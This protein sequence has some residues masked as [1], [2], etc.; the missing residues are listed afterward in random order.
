MTSPVSTDKASQG[1][2]RSAAVPACEACRKMKMK[3]TRSVPLGTAPSPTTPCDRCKRTNRTCK[4][5]ESRPL[6]R[7]RGA[8]GRYRGF[9]KAYRKLQSEAKKVN[10]SQ[11]VDEID[12]AV[13]LRRGE[14]LGV[15]SFLLPQ[16]PTPDDA[17]AQSGIVAPSH[18]VNTTRASIQVDCENGKENQ[19]L[20]AP[21]PMSNPL[22]LLAHASDAAQAI[23]ASTVASSTLNSPASRD[24]GSHNA[25]ETEGYRLLHRPG[26]ISLG[27][28]LDRSSLVQGLDTLLANLHTGHQS[29]DYFNRAGARQ[30]DVGPDLDPIELGLVTMDD[31][32][33]LFPIYFARLHP[34]N[35]ILDPMLH[36]PEFVRAR[37]SLLFTWILALTAQFDHA[38]APIA[39]R[40][41][42]HGDKLSKYVHTCGYKSVEI[43]Q[44]YY[45]SLLSATPAKTLAEERSWLYTMYAIGVATD[46]GLD[47]GPRAAIHS[48]PPRSRNERQFSFPNS[49][50]GAG[51]GAHQPPQGPSAEETAY[52][53][54][55]F[56]N[57]ERT[58]LRILLWERANSAAS[59]RI[60]S[61][62]ESN[63]T[64]SIDTW[65]LHPLSDTTD[66]YTA[67]FIILRQLLA[68]L[69]VELRDHTRLPHSDPHWVRHL[70][71]STLQDW[72]NTW[73]A[74]QQNNISMIYLHYVYA[75]GRLWTL[76]LALNSSVASTQ[77]LDAIRQDCFESAINCC[78]TA[79]RDL[80]TIGEPLYCMLAPTWAMISYAAVLTLKLFPALYG[81]RLGSDVELLS[82]LSQVA[83]QLQRAGTTPSH[84]FGIA[85]LLGQHLMMIL[86]AR[87]VGLIESPEIREP[88]PVS[89]WQ[90]AT[91]VARRE[92]LLLTDWDPFLTQA[93]SDRCDAD[94]DGFA[95]LFREIF[96]PGFGDLV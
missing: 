3:C 14:E 90:S 84:R 72:C 85:A 57:R 64:R 58:W 5:P 62:P 46:L 74:V 77:E 44:G 54:R 56:R 37:S 76:S 63:L 86:R 92:N 17:R 31:A 75:H 29:L 21:E 9:E 95:D 73:L 47:Q 36:T 33:R 93:M 13:C 7:K 43:V 1:R 65:W 94:G 42:L 91:P 11:G 16:I 87:A 22:A 10:L 59:G 18:E 15:E 41:R 79:V 24:Q 78:E 2:T 32:K 67:A 66:Q 53:Q 81:S 71:D 19:V 6:G 70:V 25:G 39:E 26:Y 30:S 4:I 69:Q 55:L 51:D 23:E 38:S 40:L 27:L 89:G 68:S 52:E 20:P 49:S 50:S 28:Q 83:T 34:V 61:F 12:G 48:H 82:L 8:L 60:H 35:G 45:I 80:E 96:G 88:R